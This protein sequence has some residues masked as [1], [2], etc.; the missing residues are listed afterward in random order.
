[1]AEMI[2]RN[3]VLG[4]V[5]RTRKNL[6]HIEYALD[7]GRDVHV[8]TQLVCSLLGLII[9]PWEQ[10]HVQAAEDLG[11]EAL[12]ARGWPEWEITLGSCTTLGDLIWH[13]RNAAAHGNLRFSSENRDLTK[14]TIFV[15]D[16][17]RRNAPPYWKAHIRADRL[18]EFCLKFIDLLHSYVG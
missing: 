9:V 6:M 16:K 17:K 10:E 4:F 15:H 18:R 12:V 7:K 13:L 5:D 14:V 1:M 11:L 2:S 8:V 3:Q